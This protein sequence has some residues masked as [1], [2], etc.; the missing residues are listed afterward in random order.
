[1]DG[2][3]SAGIHVFVLRRESDMLHSPDRN[4]SCLWPWW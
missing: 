2:E 3:T 1:M 4:V